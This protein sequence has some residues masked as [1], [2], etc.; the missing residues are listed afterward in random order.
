MLDYIAWMFL[1]YISVDLKV[2]YDDFALLS[3]FLFKVWKS[4][5]ALR[6][7]FSENG[8]FDF[9]MIP[10]LMKTKNL[11]DTCLYFDKVFKSI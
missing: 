7:T 10:G 9:A 6:L 3:E 5:V 2:K 8:G 11:S 1:V 4:L